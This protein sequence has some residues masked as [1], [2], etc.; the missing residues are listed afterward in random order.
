MVMQVTDRRLQIVYVSRV[1]SFTGKPG[2]V[3]AGWATAIRNVTWIRDRGDV[4]G[5]DH[6][7]GFVDGSW[8]TVHFWGEG[9]S[10]MSDAF[11]LRLSH[12]DPIPNL[13]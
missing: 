8:C 10:R 2:L 12:L 4:V 13:R 5:G 7:I 6:E 3:E 9:W 11:P 1:R